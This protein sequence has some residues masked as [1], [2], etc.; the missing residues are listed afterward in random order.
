MARDYVQYYHPNY[1]ERVSAKNQKIDEMANLILSQGI[2]HYIDYT[3][4][5]SAPPEEREGLIAGLAA[6]INALP[7]KGDWER[8][9]PIAHSVT[10]LHVRYRV[11]QALGKLF[12]AR[13]AGTEDIPTVAS[14]L[15]QYKRGAD[16]SLQSLIDQTRSLIS[17]VT[18]TPLAMI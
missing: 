17:T 15:A 2:R 3:M 4:I 8:L 5:Q 1:H 9:A 6:V 18:N 7:Q 16:T 14:I 10:R 13:L 11:A 12:S